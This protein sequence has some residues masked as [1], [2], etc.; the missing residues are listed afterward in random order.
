M[1]NSVKER[2]K[3]FLREY[4]IS[5]VDFCESIG[6]SSG[7]I[8][9]MRKS[10]QPDK[11][12]NIMKSYPELNIEWLLTGE[13]E[14]DNISIPEYASKYFNLIPYVP[15]DF[16]DDY[17]KQS[18]DYRFLKLLP[19][20]QMIGSGCIDIGKYDNLMMFQVSEQVILKGSSIKLN[21]QDSVAGK[22]I[23]IN[24]LPKI[25]DIKSGY[26][27]VHKKK[28]IIITTLSRCDFDNNHLY[29]FNNQ[30]KEYLLKTQDIIHIFVIVQYII[31]GIH[32][33]YD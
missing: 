33:F 20:V 22:E 2:L 14:M 16:Y 5:G 3:L 17:L 32:P 10:I 18:R 21:F 19:Q 24:S 27:I 26:V 25:A 4:N 11:L 9:G 31:N 29:A 8:S 12:I 15:Y 7:F 30:G 28:G 13:G 6:V 23:S 1:E